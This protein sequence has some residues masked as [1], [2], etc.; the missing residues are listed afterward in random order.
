[1]KR[2]Y[3]KKPPRVS[4]PGKDLMCTDEHDYCTY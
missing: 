3:V 4:D 1:M 2:M